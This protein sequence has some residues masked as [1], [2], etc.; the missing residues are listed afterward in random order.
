MMEALK[1]KMITEATVRPRR[2]LMGRMI[3]LEFLPIFD[4]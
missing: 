3:L 4:P 1:C 2:P